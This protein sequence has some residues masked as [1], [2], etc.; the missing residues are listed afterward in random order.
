MKRV[1]VLNFLYWIVLLLLL[2]MAAWQFITFINTWTL[3]DRE[4]T[5]TRTSQEYDS[6]EWMQPLYMVASSGRRQGRVSLVTTQTAFYQEAYDASWKLLRE[7]LS[8]GSLQIDCITYAEAEDGNLF[9]RYAYE[10]DRNTRMLEAACGLT[11]GILDWEGEPFSFR[12]IRIRPSGGLRT[13]PAIC[14]TEAGQSRVLHIQTDMDLTEISDTLDQKLLEICDALGDPYLDS[15]YA[16]PGRFTTHLYLRDQDKPETVTPWRVRTIPITDQTEGLS[17]AAH[18][19]DYTELI[20][21]EKYG[22]DSWIFTDDRVSVRLSAAG[23][24][25][26]VRTSVP[27]GT[28][29]GIGEAY[30]IAMEYLKRDLRI[31]PTPLEYYLSQVE[32]T[33]KG[34]VF[35]WNYMKDGRPVQPDETLLQENDMKSALQI[36]VRGSQVYRYRRWRFDVESSE[37]RI[38]VLQN[39]EIRIINE[40]KALE[41]DQIL[42]VYRIE[43]GEAVLY[44]QF[45]YKG[46]KRYERAAT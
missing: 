7:L 3:M 27:T 36:E 40:W 22:E 2:A 17:A 28:T 42:P 13:S 32:Q 43:N 25:D 11:E 35:Y 29:L 24:V 45:S 39:S 44:W 46:R 5:Y 14:L 38:R 12:E 41:W 15:A 18:F 33:P 10:S 37:I 8:A 9:C 23:I 31:D 6:S 30:E 26:C 1:K 34:Y 19:F 16:F 20:H 4:Q 21:A